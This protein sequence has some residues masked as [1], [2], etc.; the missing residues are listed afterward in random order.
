MSADHGGEKAAPAHE[1]GTAMQWDPDWN[2]W[3]CPEDGAE[4]SDA[5][6]TQGDRA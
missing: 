6:A 4:F 2:V 1:C 3:H 5:E